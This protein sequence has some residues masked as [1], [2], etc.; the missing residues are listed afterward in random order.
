MNLAQA[1]NRGPTPIHALGGRAFRNVSK[2]HLAA[3]FTD[4]SYY[5]ANFVSQNFSKFDVEC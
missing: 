1:C 5:L 2:F 4:F 3:K